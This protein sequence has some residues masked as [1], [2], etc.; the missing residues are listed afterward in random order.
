MIFNKLFV[1]GVCV[2]VCMCV[3]VCVCMPESQCDFKFAV[4]LPQSLKCLNYGHVP[5]CLAN[6]IYFLR[7]I[8]K[9]L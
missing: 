9:M 1:W 2:C 5:L 3:C 8:I 6:D 7:I 4:L